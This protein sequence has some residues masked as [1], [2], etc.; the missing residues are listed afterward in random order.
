M[1]T[2][3]SPLASVSKLANKRSDEK[4]AENQVSLQR[5]STVLRGIRQRY[6]TGRSAHPDAN[7]YSVQVAVDAGDMAWITAAIES[8]EGLLAGSASDDARPAVK[9][10]SK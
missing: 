9:A 6:Q 10:R 5:A 7:C 2:K 3:T 1:R 4:P 8:V